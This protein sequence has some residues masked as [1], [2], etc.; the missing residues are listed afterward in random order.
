MYSYENVS[1]A[2]K[3]IW[4]LVTTETIQ[5]EQWEAHFDESGK[6]ADTAIVAF[7]GCAGRYEDVYEF[8]QGWAAF[9]QGHGLTYTSMKDAIHF[10]GPY[11]NWKDNAAKRDEVLVGLAN[12]LARSK[13]RMI[14][15]PVTTAEFKALPAPQQKSFWGDVQYA[16]LEACT[17][18]ILADHPRSFIHVICDLSEE[19]SEKCVKLFNKL[20]ARNEVI[21]SRCVAITFADDKRT[22]GLQA[23]DMIAYC[24]RAEHLGIEPSDPIVTKLIEILGTHGTETGWFAW[25]VG[26]GGLGHGEI[27]PP[28]A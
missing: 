7:G 19:Y 16:A 10:H 15:T 21:K 27:E 12:M 18:G 28:V 23:A 14:A 20:R 6:L 3:G 9:L 4:N 11:E 26:G 17:M 22:L 24:A 8:C 5:G 25:K 1:H 13:L 2:L